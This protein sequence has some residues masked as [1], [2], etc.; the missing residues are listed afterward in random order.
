MIHHEGPDQGPY[1]A[2][3]LQTGPALQENSEANTESLGNQLE[4]HRTEG[5]ANKVVQETLYKSVLQVYGRAVHCHLKL[6]RQSGQVGDQWLSL[7]PL[8]GHTLLGTF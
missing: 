2:K 5:T 3:L 8:R 1:Q 6:W 7:L 4:G